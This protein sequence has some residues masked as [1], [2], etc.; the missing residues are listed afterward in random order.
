MGL[1]GVLLGAGLGMLS[2]LNLGERAAVGLVQNVIRAAHNT[3]IARSAPAS[4]R[5]DRAAGTITGFGT[6]V[7]GT[8]HFEDERLRGGRGLDGRAGEALF[9]EDGYIGRAL[10]FTG[11]P[12]GTTASIPVQDEAA[13]DPTDGFTLDCALR[14]EDTHS[15]KVLTLGNVIGLDVGGAGSV[16]GWVQLQA[17]EGS[18]TSAGKTAV[19]TPPGALTP[20]VWSR[21][22]LA[23]DRRV[24]RLSVDRVPL[25]EAQLDSPIM[26]LAG[27]LTIGDDRGSFPGS[28]DALV[29][30]VVTSSEVASLPTGVSFGPDVPPL[31]AFTPE[32]H[33]D[34]EVHRGPLAFHLAFDKGQSELVRVGQY[35]TVE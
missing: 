34:R 6:Q 2:S 33:L 16:R 31:I 18:A 1:I 10:S 29:F 23:Y 8:W 7:V 26:K 21:V 14:L 15:G 20:G 25:A 32:G 22:R 19:D 27:P 28:I 11:A 30:A 9:V 35:G 13:F 3:A 24:L 4:V 12:R 5:I 17:A